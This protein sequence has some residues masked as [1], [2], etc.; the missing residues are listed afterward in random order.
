MRKS[1]ADIVK[2][3]GNGPLERLRAKV[4]EWASVPDLR[5]PARLN[6]EQCS[7][8]ATARYKAG[9]A[10]GILREREEHGTCGDGLRR[11]ADLT[12]G[13]GVDAWAFSKVADSILYNEMD[14]GL[15]EAVR[16]N[17]GLLGVQNAVFRC[18]E[19]KPGAIAALLDDFR[20][21]LVYLDPAR[22][23]AAGR[24]VFLLEDCS[25]DLTAL[26]DELLAVCPHLLV[27]V[28]PMAD[29][30]LLRR[31][32][33]GISEI[34]ITAV[35]GECKELLLRVEPDRDDAFTVTVA[36][37]HDGAIHT[38]QLEEPSPEDVCPGVDADTGLAG[39]WLFEPG[40]ALMKSGWHAAA[41]RRAGLGKLAPSTHLYI[42]GSPVEALAPFG[43]F[44]RILE[45]FP[46]D[47]RGLREAAAKYPCADV[48]ARNIP[49]HSDE[50]ARRLGVRPGGGIHIY[51]VTAAST[52]SR[53]LL[54]TTSV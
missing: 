12:G 15:C 34:H 7:S 27:K 43:R 4:P 20:P 51:G 30:T 26:R 35:D 11:I 39:A 33:E 23:S 37:L 25:P 42:A 14:A 31:R 8:S 17:F 49:L 18:T 19:V 45:V 2:E 22:R 13:L 53:R 52:Q 10:A 1:F 16:H 24:K 48:S 54:V 32:L 40:A 50:L 3:A 28:S 29:I 44:R 36:E 38:L 9:V 46:L 6:A 21:D 41:C 5:V 47:K